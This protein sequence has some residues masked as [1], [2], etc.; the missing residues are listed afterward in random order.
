MAPGTVQLDP[1]LTL[2][3]PPSLREMRKQHRHH[4]KKQSDEKE[5]IKE[6]ERAITLATNSAYVLR[7]AADGGGKEKERRI[8]GT[9]MWT[10]TWWTEVAQHS[11]S[12]GSSELKVAAA[13]QKQRR[14]KEREFVHFGRTTMST[15]NANFKNKCVSQVNCIFCESLL[16]TRGMKAVLLAD[17][18]VELF[19][20][21]IPPNRTV[22]FV[23]SCYSTESCKCKL[24]DI[25]CLKCGNVVGYHVVAP[26]KPCLLS[27]NNGHFWMFNSDAVSTL[28]RLDATGLN[29]LLWGDLPE[30]DESEN[31]ES[32][33]PSEEEC[34]R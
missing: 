32:E 11:C 25:A 6:A 23:A 21:D 13:L 14:A 28:N 31:E 26:C 19:S 22:D 9:S 1:A 3:R 10:N 12:A 8:G 33:S 27:C 15:S 4:E 16:C 34:I 18:E 30:L 2:Q 17:T 24:R 5:E 29:L 7:E 20:T